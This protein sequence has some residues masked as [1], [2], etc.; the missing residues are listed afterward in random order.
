LNYHVLKDV[1]F[2]R[3][4]VKK[5]KN[6]NVNLFIFYEFAGNYEMTDDNVIV[7]YKKEET[8]R[9]KQEHLRKRCGIKSKIV[10]TYLVISRADISSVDVK[11]YTK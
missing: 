1:V 7:F 11:T 8:A 5:V 2:W 4:M 10:G 3:V 6:M 9:A